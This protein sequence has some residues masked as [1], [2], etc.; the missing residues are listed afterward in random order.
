VD[1]WRAERR[2]GYGEIAAGALFEPAACPQADPEIPLLVKVELFGESLSERNQ[3]LLRLD[4][5]L[6]AISN[7]ERV[8]AE[9]L[10][11]AFNNVLKRRGK[12]EVRVATIQKRRQRIWAR[13]RDYLGRQKHDD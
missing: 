12:P 9:E 5:E 13:L 2:K 7:F 10:A 6:L 1:W 8:S 4:M 11:E 3:L